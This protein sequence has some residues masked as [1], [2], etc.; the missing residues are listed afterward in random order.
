MRRRTAFRLVTAA[1]A[2][3]EAGLRPT[4][5]RASPTGVSR[6]RA[7]EAGPDREG[8]FRHVRAAFD[9]DSLDRDPFVGC[10]DDGLAIG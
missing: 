10:G 9:G 8:S 3:P 6:R 7:P 2:I 1:T 4:H 5:G